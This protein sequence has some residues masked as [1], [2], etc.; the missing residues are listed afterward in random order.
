MRLL[1]GLLLAALASAAHAQDWAAHYDKF[2]YRIPMRDGVRL[3]TAVYVP[4]QGDDG[5]DRTH[6]M[7]ME[8]TPY[9][10]HPYGKDKIRPHFGAS[11]KFF[12]LRYI[13]VNQDVRGRYMSE[14]DFEDVRP[15]KGA[16]TGPR[17][18]D[19]VTDT[20]DTIEFLVKNV[21]KNN[22]RVGVAG[23][24]YP[25]GYAAEAAMCPHP[26]LKAVSP[27]APTGDWWRGDDF[28]HNG[29]LMFQDCVGFFS[30]FAGRRV[31]GPSEEDTR[32][33]TVSWGDD[34]YDF[35]LR[36]GPLSNVDKEYF[37]GR[38]PFWNNVVKHPDFDDFWKAR[39]LPLRLRNVRPDM[40]W[41][42]GWYDAEDQFGPLA[43]YRAVRS[44]PGKGE[45]YL[46]VGPWFH[47]CWHLGEA[48]RGSFPDWMVDTAKTFKESIEFPFFDDRL[49]GHR[50]T[51]RRQPLV[52]VVNTTDMNW[53]RFAAWPPAT[54]PMSLY[55]APGGLS[56]TRPKQRGDF[57]YTSDPA[58][59]VPYY[60]GK[61]TGRNTQYMLPEPLPAELADTV[62]LVAPPLGRDVTVAGPIDVDLYVKSTGTDAD[63]V[64]R[65]GEQGETA[66]HDPAVKFIRSD[67]MRAKYRE[68]LSR[69]TPL[70]PGK[71][72]RVHFRLNDVFHTW[73][74]G[75]RLVVRVQSSW[76][77]LID[78]NPQT[79]C[80]I[81]H[82]Q[83]KDFV[84]AVQSI[85]YGPTT[86]TRVT[87][88][89]LS[90]N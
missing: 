66:G 25:G 62:T 41:V 13:I 39:S 58:K 72:E 7:L 16:R 14:G 79:F 40:L 4:K 44:R 46:V 50:A 90:S 17:D 48:N 20:Y 11:T 71:V 5:P 87:L 78:R 83:E 6:P 36:L 85:L 55:A 57:S 81:Y 21:P 59:P 54:T 68:S 77:P 63:F 53:R 64:V 12:D 74:K 9:G 32:T 37:H 52:S 84:K 56:F 76:F 80:D 49:R 33:A 88:P 18:A 26:A 73:K 89:L 47:G 42:A 15:I 67:V 23:I 45:A 30:G 60:P 69:P 28:H 35:F 34:A 31:G 10:C 82:A 70:A 27:Q 2:E 3:Y 38:Q 8:R 65:V 19:E 29:A 61:L 51:T 43:C 75:T 86:P 1:T 22:G 24:S